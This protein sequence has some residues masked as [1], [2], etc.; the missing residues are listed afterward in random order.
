MQS[1]IAL[2]AIPSVRNRA[3]IHGRRVLDLASHDGC[4]MLAALDVGARHVVASNI[5]ASRA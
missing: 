5:V 4:W 1:G 2:A 3:L